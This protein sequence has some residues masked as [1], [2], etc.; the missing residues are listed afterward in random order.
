LSGHSAG[1]EYVA[2][3]VDQLVLVFEFVG[4]SI[5]RVLPRSYARNVSKVWARFQDAFAPLNIRS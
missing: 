2:N 5:V 4:S 1:G 3:Q